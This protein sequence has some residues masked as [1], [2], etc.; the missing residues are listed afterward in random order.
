MVVTLP[1]PDSQDLAWVVA[2]GIRDLQYG[3]THTSTQHFF[4]TTVL[5]KG[6]LRC[7]VMSIWHILESARVCTLAEWLTCP[8]ADSIVTEPTCQE[9]DQEGLH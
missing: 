4:S 5:G 8:K 6:A 2:H 9:N 1:T 7:L 3:H